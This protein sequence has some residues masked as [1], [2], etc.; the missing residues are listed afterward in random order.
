MSRTWA[1]DVAHVDAAGRQGSEDGQQER[2]RRREG[3]GE[4]DGVPAS[5]RDAE[6][7]EEAATHPPAV[8]D[9]GEEE[10]Q[11]TC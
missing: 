10:L 1:E 7:P 4:G 6:V 9:G 2:G 5:A 8:Q 3:S 11:L